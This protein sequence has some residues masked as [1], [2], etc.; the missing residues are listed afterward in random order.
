MFSLMWMSSI[1]AVNISISSQK[2][3]L[4]YMCKAVRLPLGGTVHPKIVQFKFDHL[5]KKNKKSD[6]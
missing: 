6:G 4:M 3:Y 1:N 5:T 2:L